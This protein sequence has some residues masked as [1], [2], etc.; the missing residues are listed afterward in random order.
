MIDEVAKKYV[1]DSKDVEAAKERL[2]KIT[3]KYVKSGNYLKITEPALASKLLDEVK[4]L[5][6]KTKE[7]K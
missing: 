2:L 5:A 1:A 6:G 4:A 3:K 7:E